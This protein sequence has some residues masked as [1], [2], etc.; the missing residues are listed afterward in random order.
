MIRVWHA[1]RVTVAHYN[2]AKQTGTADN[3]VS[4]WSRGSA[5]RPRHGDDIIKMSVRFP[6]PRPLDLFSIRHRDVHKHGFSNRGLAEKC[7]A[8]SIP[9]VTRLSVCFAI[10]QFQTRK[11]GN[12]AAKLFS[13]SRM[14]TASRDFGELITEMFIIGANKRRTRQ[15]KTD[16]VRYL[17][18]APQS[19]NSLHV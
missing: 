11:Q 15:D 12:Y 5:Y 10:L 7:H 3:R 13:E 9:H 17:P 19:S 8:K 16:R 2:A 4:I 14:F 6:S 18:S 1:P